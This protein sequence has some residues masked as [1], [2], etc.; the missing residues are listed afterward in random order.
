M[1][2]TS[3]PLTFPDITASA[4][5]RCRSRADGRMMGGTLCLC[6]ERSS[7]GR[8][9][10]DRTETDGVQCGVESGCGVRVFSQPCQACL[11]VRLNM[12][13]RGVA[14]DGERGGEERGGEGR[15]Q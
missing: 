10:S 1:G 7:E 11:V 8:S 4:E 12:Q 14:R 5:F 6:C 3:E 13:V 9:G 2:A 15:Q